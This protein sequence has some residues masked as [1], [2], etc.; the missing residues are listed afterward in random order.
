MMFLAMMPKRKPWDSKELRQAVA[1]AIDREAIIKAVLQG[2]ARVLHGPF[3]PG[4]YAYDPNLEPKYSY[5]PEK[6]RALVKQA[7]YPDGVDVELFTPVGRYINDKQVSEAMVAMLRAVGIR[8]TLKTPE[9]P[10]LWTDVQKGRVPFYYMGRGLM[11]SGGPAI[12]QYFETDESPRIGYSNSAV[13]DLLRQ[14]RAAFDKDNLCQ[15]DQSRA[16]HHPRRGAGALP[17]A[18]QHA[19]WRFQGRQIHTA[20]R[21]PGVRHGGPHEQQ[22]ADQPCGIG[23]RCGRDRR[24]ASPARCPQQSSRNRSCKNGVRTSH[25]VRPSLQDRGND[26]RR[27]SCRLQGRHAD[28]AATGADV[29]RPDRRLRQERPGDQLHHLAQSD[30]AG[31]GRSARCGVQGHRASSARCT[32]FRSS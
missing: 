10:T 23:R 20:A 4:Q 11:I 6:A 16:Q 26:D 31:R 29:S 3:G 13:D 2:Q 18:A 21:S 14:S 17:V 30:G 25:Q 24:Q 19:L 8:A 1:Y 9:W 27:H 5:N 15:D 22:I 12:S 7:G 28:R 32:A